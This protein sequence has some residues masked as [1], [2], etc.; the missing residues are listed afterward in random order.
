MAGA[1]TPTG[2]TGATRAGPASSSASAA[3]T[4]AACGGRSLLLALAG[5]V[6]V[7][8]RGVLGRAGLRL[9]P[10]GAARPLGRLRARELLPLE[11]GVGRQRGGVLPQLPEHLDHRP[12]ELVV[13]LDVGGELLPALVLEPPAEVVADHLADMVGRRLGLERAVELVEAR[14]AGRIAAV[15]VQPEGLELREVLI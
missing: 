8:G 7:A 14:P 5:L 9:A 4:S 15:S 13:L 6:A 3:E 10:R 1:S 11:P 2:A 12:L